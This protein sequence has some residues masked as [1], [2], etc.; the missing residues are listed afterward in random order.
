M[1]D[2][3]AVKTACAKSS[4][5]CVSKPAARGAGYPEKTRSGLPE[6]Q[7]CVGLGFS[8]QESLG[9]PSAG[10]CV[11]ILLF[12]EEEAWATDFIAGDLPQ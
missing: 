1:L 3:S 8:C 12:Q 5:L 4:R 9:W 2:V 7:R 6:V 11:L 10:L